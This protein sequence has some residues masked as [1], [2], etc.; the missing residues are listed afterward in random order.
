MKTGMIKQK[1]LG[2]LSDASVLV[3]N[4][5]IPLSLFYE[6]VVNTW[7]FMTTNLILMEVVLSGRT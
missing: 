6:Q 7:S 2:A 1:V 5:T 3:S 4:Y